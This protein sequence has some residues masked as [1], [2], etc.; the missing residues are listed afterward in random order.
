MGLPGEEKKQMQAK[1][2]GEKVRRIRNNDWVVASMRGA[3][4]GRHDGDRGRVVSVINATCNL[5]LFEGDKEAVTVA[6]SNLH[7]LPDSVRTDGFQRQNKP[8]DFSLPSPSQG[9]A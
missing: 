2:P 6:T 1:E 4:T 7:V 5:V 3:C 8:R 9:G